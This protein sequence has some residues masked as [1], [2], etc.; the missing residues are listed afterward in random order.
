MAALTGVEDFQ[1]LKDRS[2]GGALRFKTGLL[3]QFP[4]QSA[5]KAFHNG[6]IPAFS[7][8]THAANS[9][10]ISQLRHALSGSVA[11]IDVS[12]A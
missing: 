7:F 4:L 11:G 3:E 9:P 6:V 2:P 5:K 10:Q 12:M 1:I 8:A